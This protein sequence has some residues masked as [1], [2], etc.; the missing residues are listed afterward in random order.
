MSAPVDLIAYGSR[1]GE[2]TAY[3]TGYNALR[4]LAGYSRQLI[5]DHGH[6]NLKMG[7]VQLDNVQNYH[8]KRDQRMGSM[9]KMN[10]GIAATYCELEETDITAFDLMDKRLR[11]AENRRA[12]LTVEQLASFLDQKHLNTVF[13]LHWLRILTHYI[14]ELSPEKS[15]V[16][17]LFRQHATK[18][19]VP[20]KATKVH[21]LASS[22][23]NETVTSELKD[24][25]V[26]FLGQ[27]GQTEQDNT[28][29]II[30]AGGDGLTYQKMIDLKRYLQFHR[31]PFQS[32]EVLEPILSPW[33]TEWTDLSRIFEVHWDSLM[34]TDPSS[35]GHSAAQI[36]RPAPSS[37]KKVD[38]Y[39]SAELM[40]LV[41]DVRILDCWRYFMALFFIDRAN[42]YLNVPYRTYFG[43][44]N[45]FE[46]FSEKAAAQALPTI[47]ELHIIA[48]QLHYA[49]SSTN[50]IY[51]ALHDTSIETGSTWAQTVRLGSAWTAPSNF[52]SSQPHCPAPQTKKKIDSDV[53]DRKGRHVKGDRVLANSITFMR[54]AMFSREMS[55]AIAEG[56]AGRVYEV[57]KVYIF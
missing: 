55:Y 42:E 19:Q 31:D 12:S 15:K 4:G 48:Q 51:H 10:I 23:K 22:G 28:G 14:L 9:N 3:T 54:D 27:M 50:G 56:D 47:E 8:R 29:Q 35:L 41:L 57:M 20:V 32:L 49:Y 17:E 40:Y 1:V 30:L 43:C 5:Q 7:F 6:D 2:M 38:Y 25:L 34:S 44:E 33:H 37:L 36:G 46:H 39:P 45:L 21:P 18:L 53:P 11:I 13:P 24:A 52:T 16:S 26:D